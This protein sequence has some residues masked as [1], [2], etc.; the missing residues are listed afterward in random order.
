M[1]PLHCSNSQFIFSYSMMQVSQGTSYVH[2][3]SQSAPYRVHSAHPLIT[4]TFKQ[5]PLAR[6]VV[7]CV[8]CVSLILM[9]PA[10]AQCLQEVKRDATPSTS[11][12]GHMPSLTPLPL[13][14]LPSTPIYHVSVSSHSKTPDTSKHVDKPLTSHKDNRSERASQPSAPITWSSSRTSVK[15]DAPIDASKL[16]S[17]SKRCLGPPGPSTLIWTCYGIKVCPH[18]AQFRTGMQLMCD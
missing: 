13:P 15:D 17:H 14:T 18:H 16:G 11:H 1:A 3:R 12:Q 2:F 9:G 6:Y 10:S 4:C 5:V 8:L 7:L